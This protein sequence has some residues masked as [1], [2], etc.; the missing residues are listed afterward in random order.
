MKM[1]S[2][3]LAL[4]LCS[5]ISIW[6]PAQ[7][8]TND[9]KGAQ[10]MVDDE[11]KVFKDFLMITS[12]NANIKK[13]LQKFAVNDVNN[14]QNNLQFLATASKDKRIKGIRSLSYF[15]KEL[16]EQLKEKKLNQFDIPLIVKKYKQTLTDL[17][18]KKEDDPI[19]KNFRDLDWRNI[20]LL[21]N[22]F[23]EFDEKKQMTD[24]SAYKRVVETP[25]YI[26]SFLETKTGFY[27]TDLLIVFMA[28]NYP[29]QLLSY[30]QKNNNAVTNSIRNNKNAYVQQLVSFS[31]NSLATEL[32]P[33]T[34]QIAN[35]ELSIDD[36]LTKRKK[37]N[38]YFQLLVNTVMSNNQKAEQGDVPEFQKALFNALYEK[39]LDFYVKKMNDLH[40][41]PDAVRFQSVQSLRPQ[42]LY[43]IIVSSDEEMYTS[44]YLG[45]YK[46]LLSHFKEQPADSILT[47]VHNDKFRKFMRIAATYNTLTDFLRLMSPERSRS[48]VHSFISDIENSDE[49]EAVANATDVADAFISLSKDP[50]F[51]SYVKQELEDG[52]KNSKRND[53]YQSQRLYSILKR[54]Y[55]LTKD[56][57]SANN[58]SANYKRLSFSSL[59]D[60]NGAISELVLFYGDEDG[61]SSYNSFMNLFK[62]KSQWDVNVND[63]WA[64]I[65]SLQG[66][67]I[68]I[69][70]NLPLK[71]EDEKDLVAQEELADYLKQQSIEPSILIHR[72]HSYHLPNTLKY[73]NTSVKLAI[74]GSC[75]GYKNMKKIMELNP[76]VHIIASKQVGSMAVNDPLL[77]QLNNELL[78]GKSLDWVDFW[79]E[80]NGT[81][82]NDANVSKLFEEYIPP[83]KNVSSY[84]IRLYNYHNDDI[85]SRQ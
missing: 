33:F 80:L 1:F 39:S 19:E 65:S 59:K 31:S 15:M 37:V 35:N 18:S 28:R 24:L 69:Y 53:R 64:T 22:A 27:Y 9:I 42:D 81:F 21:A 20:Q 82:K 84:V 83:Y 55:D 2:N 6:L 47:L 5:F 25:E 79:N 61:K 51:N 67:P 13:D 10:Q 44:T 34:E 63:S 56:D 3:F 7:T 41:S 48:L 36:I 40:S 11:Q 16:Q 74:L 72:G 8:S 54:V 85:V 32:A 60:K 57:Q 70:A 62:D 38:D 12:M 23:W 78:E 73:L 14:T 29:E 4:V 45:L 26:F 58:L 49:D 77:R 76:D 68:K 43:Y 50:L 52:L 30:I 75:G 17:L 66:Q 46:R 71:T